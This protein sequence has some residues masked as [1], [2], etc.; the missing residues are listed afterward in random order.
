[1]KGTISNLSNEVESLQLRVDSDT[2]EIQRLKN[3]I[4][5]FKEAQEKIQQEIRVT[6]ILINV[7]FKPV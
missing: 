3:E 6:I 1:M 2:K 4:I 5:K 7:F